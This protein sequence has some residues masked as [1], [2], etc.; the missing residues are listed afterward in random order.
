MDQVIYLLLGAGI[1][2]GV[3]LIF[4][5]DHP[6]RR[7]MGAALVAVCVLGWLAYSN[8][9]SAPKISVPSVVTYFGAALTLSVLAAGLHR[10]REDL[11]VRQSALDLAA[12]IDDFAQVC[13]AKIGSPFA[14]PH[15]ELESKQRMLRDEYVN[16]FSKSTVIGETAGEVYV[17]HPVTAATAVKV[18][19][20]VI[21]DVVAG[22]RGDTG[23]AIAACKLPGLATWV[24]KT[25]RLEIT[26]RKGSWLDARFLK[27]FGAYFLSASLLWLALFALAHK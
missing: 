26:L 17:R 10:W 8:E 2:E 5:E 22:V 12:R 16:T 24:A 18:A 21:R 9:L 27:T 4:P 13:D 3:Y 25:L 11:R 14:V 23:T 1:Y 20:V 15:A 7:Q 6:N 19:G